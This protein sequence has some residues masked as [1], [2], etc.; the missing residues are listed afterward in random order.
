M[1]SG[2]EN[3]SSFAVFYKGTLVVNI[4]GGYANPATEAKW[5]KETMATAFSATKGVAAIAVARLVDK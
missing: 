4:W 1:E 2:E 3:G 5:R